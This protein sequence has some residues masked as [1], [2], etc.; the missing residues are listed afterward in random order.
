MDKLTVQEK[1]LIS[2]LE[3]NNP[4]TVMIAIKEIRHHGN[5]RML[6][7]LFRLIQPSTHKIIRESIF[8]LI[9][10]IKTQDAVPIIVSMLEQAD[11]SVDFFRLV[12]ACWQSDLDFSG[13]IPV[14]IR[15]FVDGDYQ[16]AVEAFSVIEESIINADQGIQ[17]SCLQLLEKTSSQVSEEKYPLFRELIKIVSA[18]G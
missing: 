9:G 8:M 4:A 10:E 5:I 14:F 6:P 3:S 16:T 13:H 11:R 18:A 2:Q 1:E 17:R 15:I 7:Y 12:A